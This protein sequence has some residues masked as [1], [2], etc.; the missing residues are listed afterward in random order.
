VIRDDAI[1]AI[2]PIR[3]DPIEFDQVEWLSREQLGGETAGLLPPC[4]VEMSDAD[5]GR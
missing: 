5:Q 4:E 1:V 2:Q 3:R